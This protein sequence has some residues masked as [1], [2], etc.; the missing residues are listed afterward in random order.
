MYEVRNI[1]SAFAMPVVGTFKTKDEVE[2]FIKASGEV[3]L[4]ETDP[5]DGVSVDAL[6]KTKSGI[7][8]FA[9]NFKKD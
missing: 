7:V 2:A 4:M 6:V 8:Q 9:A 1:I 3:V 5:D